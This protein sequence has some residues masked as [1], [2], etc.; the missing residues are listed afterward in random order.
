MS[1][2]RSI[3]IITLGICLLLSAGCVSGAVYHPARTIRSTPADAKLIYEDVSLETSDKVRISGWWIPAAQP[4]GTVLFCHGNAGNIGDRLDTYLAINALGFNTFAFDYR[5]YGT[6]GGSPS[7]DGTYEDADAAWN[8]LVATQGISPQ[9][10]IIWGRSLGG[11][12]AAR[13]AAYHRAGLVIV[14]SSFT[15]VKELA[16][17]LCWW[18][19][20]FLLARYTYDTR[21]YLQRIDV[22]VLVIHSADD[23]IITFHHGET[24]YKSINGQKEFLRIRGSHNHGFIDSMSVYVSSINKFIN[25]YAQQKE[26]ILE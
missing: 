9:H 12:I 23:E 20:S 16:K 13:T 8:Y 7:E 1:R 4:R 22:P 2:L 24:L 18:V 5:G 25:R 10:I 11:A 14:E 6:S 3:E 26:A 19:P 17:D 21:G 15:S